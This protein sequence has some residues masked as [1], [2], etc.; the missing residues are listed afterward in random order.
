MKGFPSY[1]LRSDLDRDDWLHIVSLFLTACGVEEQFVS[2]LFDW[3]PEDRDVSLH[4]LMD[5]LGE[6]SKAG[7]EEEARMVTSRVSAS[8][9]LMLTY[10]CRCCMWEIRN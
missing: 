7:K 6:F 10:F 9:L 3:L 2:Q 4:N 8:G 1:K 5:V